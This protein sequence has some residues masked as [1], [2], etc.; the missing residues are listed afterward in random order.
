MSK[1]YD[2]DEPAFLIALITEMHAIK[3][4]SRGE[5][6]ALHVAVRD[7]GALAAKTATPFKKR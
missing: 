2:P 5:E 7:L 4:R 3:V 1:V 6:I